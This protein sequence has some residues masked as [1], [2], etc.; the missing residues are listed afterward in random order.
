MKIA[1]P[2][3]EGKLCAHFGHCET[4][5]F[6]EVNPETKEIIKIETKTPQEGVS[7]K[8]ADWIAKQGVSVVL[9]GGMGARPMEAFKMNN[10]KVTTLKTGENQC[11]G[12]GHTHT[13]CHHSHK[14]NHHK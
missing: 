12:E 11:Q 7:C 2:V 9:A 13:H 5:G 14:C 3:L 8:S 4:F 10:V 1:L 6:V